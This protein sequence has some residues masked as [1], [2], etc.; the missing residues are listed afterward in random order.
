MFDAP[1]PPDLPKADLHDRLVRDL[2]ALFAG[3]GDPVANAANMASLLFH[4]LPDLNWA[5]FYI[6]RGS[7]LALGPFQGKPACVRIPAGR[8][9]CGAAVL[10]CA[11]QV[12]QLGGGSP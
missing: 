10:R 11:E 3:E 2:G 6:L 12:R 9:V 8:G 7:D 4:A 1:P 5:G